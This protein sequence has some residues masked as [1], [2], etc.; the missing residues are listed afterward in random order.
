MNIKI[1]FG[2]SV[3]VT[4]TGKISSGFVIIRGCENM[5]V[6]VGAFTLPSTAR[7]R[8]QK[9]DSKLF[10]PMDFVPIVDLPSGD[11]LVYMT[12]I[13]VN[14]TSENFWSV[15]VASAVFFV[16]RVPGLRFGAPK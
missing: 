11:G 2:T 12:S 15:A 7:L 6:A 10:Q 16:V 9:I 8:L 13:A 1:P 5:P 14:S 4:V 3:V